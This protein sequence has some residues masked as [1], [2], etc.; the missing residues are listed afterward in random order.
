MRAATR[1]HHRSGVAAVEFALLLPF[2]TFT[3]FLGTDWCRIFYVAHTLQDC[4]RSGALAA[5]GIAYQE[6]G[7]TYQERQA[8]GITEALKDGTNLTPSIQNSDITVDTSED[9]VWVTVRYDFET[10]TSLPVVGGS[11]TVE[12]TVRM[13]VLP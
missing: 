9:Y 5:S 11:W 2:I 8:R 4:A 12:R 3:F 6:H 1:R 13:P 10:M 7:L